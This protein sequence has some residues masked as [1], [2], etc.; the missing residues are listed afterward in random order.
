MKY[1]IVLTGNIKDK[2]DFDIGWLQ[3][4]AE[5]IHKQLQDIMS[6]QECNPSNPKTVVT[7]KNKTATVRVSKGE[8]NQYNF[9]TWNKEVK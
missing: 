3:Q 8:G 7:V 2:T 4:Q 1:R 9:E 5:N 6:I